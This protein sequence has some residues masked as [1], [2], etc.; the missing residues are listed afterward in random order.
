MRIPEHPSLGNHVFLNAS[1]IVVFFVPR[2]KVRINI[3]S[4][5]RPV[6]TNN[7]RTP[8]YLTAGVR[9]ITWVVPVNAG[10]ALRTPDLTL[11]YPAF[12]TN[13]LREPQP[14]LTANLSGNK[15]LTLLPRT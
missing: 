12:H 3:R 9:R 14:L 2:D 7:P 8:T 11:E 6:A 15:P 5:R 4:Y 10:R 1:L 13:L